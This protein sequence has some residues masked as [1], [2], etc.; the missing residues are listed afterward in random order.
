MQI[1]WVRVVEWSTPAFELTEE[2]SA[3]VGCRSRWIFGRKA[4]RAVARGVIFKGVISQA[5]HL[6]LQA[7]ATTAGRHRAIVGGNGEFCFGGYSGETQI[8]FCA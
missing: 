1:D 5:S 3:C 6:A 7:V 8:L 4:S 2:R